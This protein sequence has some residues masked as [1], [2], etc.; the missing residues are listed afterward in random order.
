M[1]IAGLGKSE[2]FCTLAPTTCEASS[3]YPSL[4]ETVSVPLDLIIEKLAVPTFAVV[5]FD[6]LP[7]A[8]FTPFLIA[9]VSVFELVHE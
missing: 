6:G 8:A 2:K 7:T 9:S 5:I 3:P 1:L 4:A